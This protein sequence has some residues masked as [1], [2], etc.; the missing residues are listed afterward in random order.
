MEEKQSEWVGG[1]EQQLWQME[2]VVVLALVWLTLGLQ[3]EAT[4]SYTALH[5]HWFPLPQRPRSPPSLTLFGTS[6]LS[7]P[8]Q[9][10]THLQ[11]AAAWQRW[12][13]LRGAEPANW[14]GQAANRALTSPPM[15]AFACVCTLDLFYVHLF[16]FFFLHNAHYYPLRQVSSCFS[17]SALARRRHQTTQKHQ[18]QI[19]QSLFNSEGPLW[20]ECYHSD[21]TFSWSA[22]ISVW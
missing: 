3:P 20:L 15:S 13:T 10:K 16:F 19:L 6:H 18:K 14:D 4:A 17:L 1:S 22:M 2:L 9:T 12:N 7:V 11:T 5:T 8:D 21:G